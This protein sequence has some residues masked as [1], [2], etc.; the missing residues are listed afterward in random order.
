M[1]RLTLPH[2]FLNEIVLLRLGTQSID[3]K[4]LYSLNYFFTEVLFLK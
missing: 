1:E 4:E 2:F 3:C